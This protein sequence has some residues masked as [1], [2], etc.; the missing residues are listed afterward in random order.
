M[1]CSVRD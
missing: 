1:P